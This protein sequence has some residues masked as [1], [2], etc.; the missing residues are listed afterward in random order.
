MLATRRTLLWTFAGGCLS[1]AML[2]LSG[3]GLLS[4]WRAEFAPFG[5]SHTTS[6]ATPAHEAR[7]ADTRPL[8][9][10]TGKRATEPQAPS[11]ASATDDNKALA[12]EPPPSKPSGDA[13][14]TPEPGSSVAEVLIRLETQYR[15]GLTTA[16]PH[17]ALASATS[18]PTPA[19]PAVATTVTV[20]STSAR[21]VPAQQTQVSV[22][23]TVAAP[24][25]PKSAP[26]P[27]PQPLPPPVAAPVAAPEPDVEP[28]A[29]AEPPPPQEPVFASND[30]PPGGAAG[31]QTVNI[32]TLNQGDVYNIQQYALYQ[33]YAS[34]IGGTGYGGYVPPSP[35]PVHGHHM[36]HSGS[37]FSTPPLPVAAPPFPPW[38]TSLTVPTTP[39]S[40]HYPHRLR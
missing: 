36:G 34:S 12:A 13:T 30:M 18:D 5:A 24:E 23:V 10:S 11:P 28:L 35:A 21:D 22:A 40:Y 20:T 17:D 8:P 33:Q 25:P 26:E 27:A 3:V 4:I 15:Q 14:A 19:S 32:G 29:P 7:D 2:I 9:A 16:A 1:G 39:M 38:L 6:D 37:P 31:P